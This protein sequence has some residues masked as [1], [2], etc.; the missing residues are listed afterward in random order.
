MGSN[1]ARKQNIFLI[2]VCLSKEYYTIV[3][4][5][6]LEHHQLCSLSGQNTSLMTSNNKESVQTLI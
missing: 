1:L 4:L 6:F 5:L 3:P 2:S